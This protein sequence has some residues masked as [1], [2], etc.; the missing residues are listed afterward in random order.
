M[1]SLIFDNTFFLFNESLYKQ[2]DGLAMGNPLAPAMANIFL[3]HLEKQIFD[4]CPQIFR[5]SFYRRYLDDTFAIFSS[6]HEA[7]QF[8]NFINSAHPNIKFTMEKEHNNSLPFL[9]LLTQYR[10]SKLHSSIYRKPTFTGL[11]LNFFSYCPMKH[12]INS[13][14]TLIHRA[15]YLS[16]NYQYFATEID[17]LKNFFTNNGYPL[18]LF[19]KI[20]GSFLNRIKTTNIPVITVPK[21]EFYVSLPY[22]GPI[23]HEME[24][25][26]L[27]VLNPSYPQISFKFSFKNK[28]QLKSFFNFKDRLPADLRSHIIYEFQCES[29]QDSYIG[30][31]TKQAKVRFSQH[32]G[33]SPRTDRHVTSP[34]HSSPR[35]HCENKNHPFKYSN[36]SIID[37]APD[38]L[39][40]RIMESLYILNQHPALNLDRS[41][42]PLSLF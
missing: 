12:K 35:Q 3:C 2:T 13:I 7:N 28:F 17:Y 23:S 22:L 33:V 38:E 21:D 29:C 40:L 34:S 31:T 27:K 24:R 9:D 19:E 14:K 36:F 30:S 5:P 32:L 15:Y 26:F 8:F 18:K 10:D 1:L 6:E 42:I 37:A 41:S 16:S 20:V 11:A 25:F 4:N 39:Q